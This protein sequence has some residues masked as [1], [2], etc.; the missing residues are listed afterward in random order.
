MENNTD[1]IIVV[2]D[3][4]IKQVMEEHPTLYDDLNYN[5][6]TIKE[7]LEKQPYYY[8]QYR[9]LYIKEK[10][11][12]ERVKQLRDKYIGE[13]YEELKYGD[14]KLTK[15]EIERYFIPKDQKAIKFEKLYMKQKI[16]VETFEAITKA[17]EQQ[18]YAM[19]NFIKNM[20]L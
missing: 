19:A 5:E 2:E 9:L 4:I 17:F 14:R 16:R 13:L 15:T 1:N 7:K 11:H 3:D 12:L 6:Y 10:G 18:G 8:Q 20:Q